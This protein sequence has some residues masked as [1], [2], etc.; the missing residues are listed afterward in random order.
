MLVT[1][2]KTKQGLVIRV[3]SI[4][5]QMWDF[6]IFLINRIAVGS[7]DLWIHM[8]SLWKQKKD[9]LTL[10]GH[11]CNVPLAALKPV[12]VHGTVVRIKLVCLGK[13]PQLCFL[14]SSPLWTKCPPYWQTT[15]SNA[16]SWMKFI[17]FPFKSH[18]NLFQGVQLTISHYLNQCWLISPMHICGTRGRWVNKVHSVCRLWS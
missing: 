9:L 8:A 5:F 4:L 18:W 3:L 15:I 17:E 7:T 13:Q 2:P 1:W 10:Q 12:A 6:V 14:N 11:A 16:F